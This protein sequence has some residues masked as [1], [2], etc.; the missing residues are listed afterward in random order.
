LAGAASSSSEKERH[1]E[2]VESI[3]AR[4]QGGLG[5]PVVA[6]DPDPCALG[7]VSD[8]GLH[9]IDK[10]AVYFRRAG[11]RNPMNRLLA[12]VAL[13][14]ALVFAAVA[15]PAANDPNTKEGKVVSVGSGKLV[16][17]ENPG[18]QSTMTVADSAVVT[19]NGKAAKLMDLKKGIQVRIKT[20]TAGDV[21]SITTMDGPNKA[22]SS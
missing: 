5:H 12:S 9:L 18:S 10:C 13:A 22:T 2:S 1:H 20:N 16:L 19:I 4:G 17:Q 8:S 15:A 14:M 7:A 3:Y 21:V 6:R 11:R